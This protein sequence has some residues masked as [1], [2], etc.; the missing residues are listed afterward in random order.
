MLQS[1]RHLIKLTMAGAAAVTFPKGVMTMEEVFR[2]GLIVQIIA[3]SGKRDAL[4]AILDKAF[5][6]IPGMLSHVIAKDTENMNAIWVTEAWESKEA[7]G[8]CFSLPAVQEAMQDGRPM[9][10]EMGQR[11]ETIPVAGL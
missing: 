5:K 9:I 8:A 6:D 2:Y 4:I 3:K 10:A 1:R 11:V 7:H